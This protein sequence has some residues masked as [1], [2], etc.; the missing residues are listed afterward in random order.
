VFVGVSSACAV[1][2]GY[3]PWMMMFQVLATCSMFY[4]A[5]WATFVSGTMKFGKIDVTEGQM[6]IIGL[7]GTAALAGPS[8]WDVY[9]RHY[10]FLPTLSNDF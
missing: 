5:H 7:M 9:V 8:L 3:A 1:S 4:I 2:L 10:A 6:C